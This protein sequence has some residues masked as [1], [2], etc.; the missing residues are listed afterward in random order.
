[1]KLAQN[2]SKHEI[3]IFASAWSPP[4]WMKANNK[5]HSGSLKG[6]VGGK[7]YQIYADYLVK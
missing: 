7:Y 5:F 6:T 1:M 4:V 2:V 3:K